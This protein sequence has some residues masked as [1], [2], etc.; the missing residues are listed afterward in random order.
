MIE[1]A[2]AG[3]GVRADGGQASVGHATTLHLSSIQTA[4]TLRRSFAETDTACAD[5]GELSINPKC[6]GQNYRSILARRERAFAEGE[7]V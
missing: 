6:L 3:F 4:I 5:C 7:I 2:A 1:L